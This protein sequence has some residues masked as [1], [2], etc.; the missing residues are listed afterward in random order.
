MPIRP[1][2]AVFPTHAGRVA[3]VTGAAQG[4]GQ[5]FSTRL[6]ER[7]AIVV[8]IDR[9]DL[10]ETAD[11]VASNRGTFYAILADVSSEGETLALAQKVQRDCGRCD[12]LINNA[13]IYDPVPWDSLDF[14]KW[15]T[16]FSVNLDGPFLMCKAL[17]PLMKRNSYGRIV[18]IVSTTFNMPMPVYIAYRSAKMGLVGLT[19]SLASLG[20]NGITANC[21]SPTLTR[22]PGSVQANSGSEMLFDSIRDTQSIKLDAIPD[23]L[24]Y[25]V[26]F[27]TS[28]ESY[29]I[30]GQ[31]VPV[32]GGTQFGMP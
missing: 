27:L 14:E 31:A 25:A 8:G 20:D 22:T 12:I 23:D 26:M 24:A 29:W 13:A 5:T 10:R 30:T 9:S 6:A 16:I 32:D 21:V 19:R 3:V 17:V 28:E 7:G 15:R 11:I 1:T 18:N 2:P 4:L